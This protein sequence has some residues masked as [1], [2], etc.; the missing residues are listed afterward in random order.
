MGILLLTEGVRI[1]I[2][3]GL[4]DAGKTT[5]IRQL[6]ESAQDRANIATCDIGLNWAGVEAVAVGRRPERILMEAT[7]DLGLCKAACCALNEIAAWPSYM[8]ARVAVIDAAHFSRIQDESGFIQSASHIFLNRAM[9]IQCTAKARM[10]KDIWRI[11]PRANI[12][13]DPLDG[14]DLWKIL[15][16]I[17]PDEPPW[18]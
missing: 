5:F 7:C 6:L 8:G 15:D 17:P 3:A 4:P 13:V 16:F 18:F 9:D 11:N 14:L 10:L 2:V 1:D 12:L